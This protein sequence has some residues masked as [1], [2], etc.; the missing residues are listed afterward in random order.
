M[1]RGMV[2]V[3]GAMLTF[4]SSWLGLVLY[5]FAQLQGEQPYADP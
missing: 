3:V 2:I 5:P 1:D 4:A